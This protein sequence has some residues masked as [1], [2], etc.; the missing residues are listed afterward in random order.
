MAE[1]PRIVVLGDSITRGVRPGVLQGQTFAALLQASLRDS[2]IDVEVIN[3]G[4]GGER[5]DQA[6]ARL[7]RDILPLE[8]VLVTIM[9]GTNDSY[10]DQGKPSSRLS[11]EQ[12]QQNL[13]S[14]VAELKRVGIQPVLMTEPRWAPQASANGLGEHPNKR[15]QVYSEACRKVASAAEIPLVDHFADW[16]S[17]ERSG[18]DINEWTTDGCHPNAEG[19]RVLAQ[20]MLPLIRDQLKAYQKK[21]L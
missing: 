20:K 17:A 13:T 15:L 6:L 2:G 11:V 7:S 4:I 19:H 21:S 5:T 18:V 14:I 1:S 12:Y 9:Y 8:P 3:Q 10:V 16:L